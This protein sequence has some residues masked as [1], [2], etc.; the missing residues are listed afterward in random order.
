MTNRVLAQFCF[1]VGPVGLKTHLVVIT[2]LLDAYL[3]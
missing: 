3:E 1:T 2:P